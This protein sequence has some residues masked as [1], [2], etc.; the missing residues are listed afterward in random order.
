M[1]GTFRFG[2]GLVIEPVAFTDIRPG[3]IVV[4][5]GVNHNGEE[6]DLV[7]RVISIRP[8][9]LVTQGDNN[10][11]PDKSLV[12]EG[13][14]LGR[15]CYVERGG[16]KIPVRNGPMGLFRA[17]IRRSLDFAQSEVWRLVRS[18]GRGPY[19]RVRESGLVRLFWHPAISKVFLNTER[20]PMIKYICRNRTV[21]EYWPENGRLKCR[22]PYD[23]VLWD[24]IA[25]MRG[26]KPSGPV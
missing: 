17:R 21:G 24:R 16:R 9:G 2:D 22:K 8:D 15:V 20:G 23:L 26:G 7:H 25:K 12:N 10:Y 13:S 4:Y 11:S 19:G 6:D 5:Q 3:D 1:E 18:V 14:L